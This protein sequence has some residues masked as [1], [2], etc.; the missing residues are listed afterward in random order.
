MLLDLLSHTKLKTIGNSVH[1]DYSL[2][3][4]LD[5]PKIWEMRLL[6]KRCQTL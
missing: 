4:N 1:V 3:P 2:V 5:L 6:T